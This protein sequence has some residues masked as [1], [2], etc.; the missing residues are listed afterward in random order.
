[1]TNNVTTKLYDTDD[2]SE[3]VLKSLIRDSSTMELAKQ[4]KMKP[5]D[6][7]AGLNGF[8][9]YKEFAVLAFSLGAPCDKELFKMHISIQKEEGIYN[10]FEPETVD[11][12]FEYIFN[13]TPT[14]IEYVAEHLYPMI[15]H[16]RRKKIFAQEK[17]DADQ[18]R[19]QTELAKLSDEM[20]GARVAASTRDFTPFDRFVETTRE[21]GVLTGVAVLDEKVGGLNKGECGLILGHSGSGKTALAS[22]L[23]R[24]SAIAGF[25]A[26]YLSAEEPAENI[27]NRW[28]AQQFN[29]NYS[30]LHK[31]DCVAIAE[32]RTGFSDMESD[33]RQKLMRLRIKDVRDL[34]PLDVNDIKKVLEQQVEEGFI[35]D[36]VMIDQ[37]DYLKARITPQKNAAKWEMYE[38]VAFDLDHLS[39]Y[40]VAGEHPFA[41]WVLHQATGDMQ[42]SFTYNDI[43]GFK[44]IVRPFDLAIG[45]GRED[46][47]SKHI[48]LFSLKVRHSEQFSA[49][50]R[51]EFEYMKF[52]SD[53]SYKPKATRDREERANDKKRGRGRPRKN[54]IEDI[55]PEQPPFEIVA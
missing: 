53:N 52:Y 28:Y 40:K 48:N 5:E 34:A 51:A 10:D 54:P 21:P 36:V 38:K 18:L 22:Y 44:G 39:Q 47:E 37:M 9:I 26:L 15:E 23:M 50:Y 11:E 42:W 1:M 43:A 24:E 12:L 19:C 4:Y 25:N 29:I 13:N 16:R 31:G 7:I 41:L 6:L 20:K 49:P 8:R 46:R 33:D 2:L 32:A 35:P 55:P 3:I 30:K 27:I 17:V 45:I 14:K